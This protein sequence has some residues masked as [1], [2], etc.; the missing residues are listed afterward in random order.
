MSRLLV[1]ICGITKPED[2]R[3]AVEA[4]ADALGFVFWYMSQRN[5]DPARAAA[6]ARELPRSVLRVGVF[7]QVSQH[8]GGDELLD[9][10]P[11]LAVEPGAHEGGERRA[12]VG[13]LDRPAIAAIIR[14]GHCALYTP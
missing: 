6:I 1:K 8:L 10:G 12:V 13:R 11:R 5:V 3:A 7:V 9:G 4:G 2:A 14:A